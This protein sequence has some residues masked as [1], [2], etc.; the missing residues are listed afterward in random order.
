MMFAVVRPEASVLPELSTVPESA[1][2]LPLFS[3]TVTSSI[4][5]VILPVPA[6]SKIIEP[7]REM[8]PQVCTP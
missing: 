2:A 1:M 7:A 6:V 4:P 8:G 3:A 5:E